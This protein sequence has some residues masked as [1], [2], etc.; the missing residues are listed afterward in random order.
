M[1]PQPR[2]RR[3]GQWSEQELQRYLF[4]DPQVRDDVGVIGR[5]TKAV[6]DLGQ[7]VSRLM[8][9]GWALLLTLLAALLALVGGLIQGPGHR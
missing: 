8:W 6:E 5:L 1:D 9:L 7:R 3:A 2:R 4:G